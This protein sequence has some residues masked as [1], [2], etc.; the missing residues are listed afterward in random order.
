MHGGDRHK[1]HSARVVLL[2]H[3][4]LR[5]LFAF[6]DES[7]LFWYY[8]RITRI[9]VRLRATSLWGEAAADGRFTPSTSEIVDT[10]AIIDNIPTWPCACVPSD[11]SKQAAQQSARTTRTSSPVQ[12]QIFS[13]FYMCTRPPHTCHKM[14]C[15]RV[16]WAANLLCA[17]TSGGVG[18]HSNQIDRGTCMRAMIRGPLDSGLLS[19]GRVQQRISSGCN[20]CAGQYVGE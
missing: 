11:Q 19:G 7:H 8:A 16:P 20:D 4:A 5:R 1:R 3:A 10:S 18:V 2:T 17:H 15:S 13:Q 9:S 6:C 12:C 14:S